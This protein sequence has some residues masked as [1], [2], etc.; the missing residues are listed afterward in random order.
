MVN[1]A[2]PFSKLESGK[3]F[4]WITNLLLLLLLFLIIIIIIII[5]IIN[6]FIYLIILLTL[7][8]FTGLV[9]VERHYSDR[10]V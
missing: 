10:E 6:P 4:E 5:I 3:Y 2:C 8:D 9:Q 1:Y 7:L